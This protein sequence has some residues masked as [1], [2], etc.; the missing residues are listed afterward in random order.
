MVHCL[1]RDSEDGLLGDDSRT[2]ELFS[3]VELE[4]RVRRG[5]SRLTMTAENRT[6]N[7]TISTDATWSTCWLLSERVALTRKEHL[8]I[9]TFKKMAQ[10]DGPS[11]IKMP[12]LGTSAV[13]R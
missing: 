5:P 9:A 11:F 10:V 8:K 4:T 13:G 1:R 6:R 7:Y 2:A 12:R 3:Y